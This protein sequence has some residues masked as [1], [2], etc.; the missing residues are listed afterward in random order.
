VKKN[1]QKH[2]AKNKKMINHLI[3]LK[4]NVHTHKKILPEKHF[5]KQQ[6]TTLFAEKPK[7]NEMY[8]S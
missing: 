7:Q 5:E 1:H 6:L 8:R 2:L 3:G 4:G